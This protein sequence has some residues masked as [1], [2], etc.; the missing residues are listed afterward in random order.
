MLV[1]GAAGGV[2]LAAVQIAKAA[3]CV[4]VAVARGGAKVGAL[5]EAGADFALD[6]APLGKGGL[7]AAV[8]AA[9]PQGV[10]VVF[11]PVGG[12]ALMEALQTLKWGG[13]IAARHPSVP[14]RSAVAAMAAPCAAARSAAQSLFPSELGAGSACSAHGLG[15]WLGRLLACE[16]TLSR[17]GKG[18]PRL[19]VARTV[20]MWCRALCADAPSIGRVPDLHRG[21][22]LG[23]LV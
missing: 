17:G 12:A 20:I 8:K 9:V 21:S 2:G 5:R 13:Q 15:S 7:R 23:F 19:P 22:A 16:C 10:D 14:A 11:D 3:G 1:L 6:S 18:I 4:V